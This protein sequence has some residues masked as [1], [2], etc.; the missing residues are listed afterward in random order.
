MKRGFTGHKRMPQSETTKH[1]SSK[2]IRIPDLGA[3][4]GLPPMQEQVRTEAQKDQ[5]A[6]AFQRLLRSIR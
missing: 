6:R 3:A 4:I 1:A 5:D 2:G